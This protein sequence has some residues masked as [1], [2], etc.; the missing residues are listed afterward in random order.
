MRT[1]A[2]TAIAAGLSAVLIAAGLVYT[3]AA[4]AT[5]G[6]TW[7]QNG[8]TLGVDLQLLDSGVYIVEPW[9][10]ICRPERHEG[11]WAQAGDRITLTPAEP[12]ERPRILH[13]RSTRGCEVLIPESA[14]KPSGDFASAA[15][16]YREGDDC[17]DRAYVAGG[18]VAAP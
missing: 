8:L 4:T 16:Y 13:K 14:L 17:R 5:P 10:D 1:F 2:F 15:A 18:G 6:E 3:T 11:R 12:G 9:C 7:H